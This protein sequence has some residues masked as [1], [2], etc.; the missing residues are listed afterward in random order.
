M[1]IELGLLSARNAAVHSRGNLSLSTEI[2][3]V[4]GQDFALGADH[5]GEDSDIYRGEPPARPSSPDAHSVISSRS[6]TS[7]SSSGS[8]VIGRRLGAIAAVVE[9]AI[10]R[11]A[12]NNASI[13]SSASS[14]SSDTSI[15][16]LAKSV[17]RRRRRRPSLAFIHDNLQS[18]REI[19][20]RLKAREEFRHTSR[21]FTLYLPKSLCQ[22][23]ATFEAKDKGGRRQPPDRVARTTSLPLVLH[24]LDAAL[25]KSSKVHRNYDRPGI[26]RPRLEH[27][28]ENDQLHL[29][30]DYML[31][32]GLDPSI[33]GSSFPN[34][35]IPNSARKGK[36][37]EE[38]R[39]KQPVS[40]PSSSAY[41][42]NHRSRPPPQR[43]WWIDVASPTWEDMKAFGQLLHI[44][45]LTLEDILQQDPR[46]KLEL[47]PKL[48]YYFIVFKALESKKTQ[49]RCHRSQAVV[50]GDSHIPQGE[51]YVG[52]A[53]VY[54]V[55][56]R[57]GLV[58][59]HFSD[60]SDHTDHVRN[61]LLLL[62]E[63]V[64]V[65]NASSDWIAHG[66]LDSIV[67]SFFPFQEGL[68]KEIES[69]EDL[70]FSDKHR[71]V[72]ESFL[73]AVVAAETEGS[74]STEKAQD[75]PIIDEKQSAAVAFTRTRF[76][77]PTP[78]IPLMIR[79][80]RRTL[81]SRILPQSKPTAERRT[82]VSAAVMTL[83]R[84]MKARRLFTTSTRLLST[85]HEVVAQIK[86]RLLTESALPKVTGV[87]DEIEVAMYMGDVQDHILTLQHSLVHYERILVQLHQTYLSQHR[88]S[89]S[90]SKQ[91]IDKAIMILS[92]ISNAVLVC[93][94][95][96]GIFSMNV[97]IPTNGH[98]PSSPYNWFYVVLVFL[99][100]A[101]CLFGHVVRLWWV[102]A[103]RKRS[104]ILQKRNLT[105]SES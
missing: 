92:I 100:V 84:I 56:F 22:T 97:T 89:V 5:P 47:F 31:P 79:R 93:Q 86:K 63:D 9:H 59:F 40:S 46:E 62:D 82:A 17:A 3:T 50:T 66:I 35:T 105:S 45:P 14:V 102:G 33:R 42:S 44:H 54:L 96:I 41:T 39:A 68:E 65:S 72:T 52:E 26:S 1:S 10:A 36:H 38:G 51:D 19:A 18:E 78:T 77:L 25:K 7:S 91:G 90:T 11:W 98:D 34:V 37:K 49:E 81:R 75:S 76:A 87:G 2:P 85:K 4:S 8:S 95:V 32:N 101:L 83:R 103:K 64:H 74:E 104:A 99:L 16:T 20:A 6:S 61:K 15:R 69:I 30:R 58:S 27:S 43:A 71:T 53:M 29:H 48:G 13:S 12:R 67:D 24:Y 88:V 28:G 23:L 73:P 60:I 55:V 80:L 94:V 57:E 70:I 21:E